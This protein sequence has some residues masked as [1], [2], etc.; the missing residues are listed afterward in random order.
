MNTKVKAG[1]SVRLT[2]INWL[3][4]TLIPFTKMRIAE[5][6]GAAPQVLISDNEVVI[7][8]PDYA[9]QL[10]DLDQRLKDLGG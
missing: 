10:N 3:I 5:V 9:S 4:K 1:W 7:Q 2:M 8:I 6:R